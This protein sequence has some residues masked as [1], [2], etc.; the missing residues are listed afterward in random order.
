MENVGGSQ[1][2]LVLSQQFKSFWNVDDFLQI[3]RWNRKFD[4]NWL[5]SFT[6]YYL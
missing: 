5:Q 6:V 1:M 2:D 3:S 4:I